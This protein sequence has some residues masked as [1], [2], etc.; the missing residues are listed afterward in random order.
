MQEWVSTNGDVIAVGY[1]ARALRQ[2]DYDDGIKREFRAASPTLLF[3]FPS[4]LTRPA[5][6]IRDETM[7]E[8]AGWNLLER[9]KKQMCPAV[10]AS[11]EKYR[12]DLNRL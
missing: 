7:D 3:P 2:R 9:K 4:D 6:D 1:T 8:E 11:R 10:L 12:R 5:A